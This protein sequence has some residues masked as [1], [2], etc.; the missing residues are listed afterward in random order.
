MTTAIYAGTFDP[1]TSGHLSVVRQAVKLFGHVVVLVADNPA[2]QTLFPLAER[3][4]MIRE[5]AR[6][7]PGVTVASTSGMVVEYAR[8]AGAG[9]L[10]RGIRGATDAAF[11]T[12]LAKTNKRLAPEI[13]T[14]FLPAEA[15]LAETSSSRLKELARRGED[16]SPFCTPEVARRLAGRVGPEP[17]PALR[18]VPLGIGDAFTA[19]HYSFCLA[20]ESAGSWLLVDC[21]HPIQKMIREAEARANAG[22][23]AERIDHVVLTH[24]HADHCSGLEGLA[25]F[26]HFERRQK[27]R[28]VAHPAVRERLWDGH[29]AAGM[30]R[31]LPA[32]EWRF[33]DYFEYTALDEGR[34]V[35]VGPFRI[36]CRRTVHHIPTTALRISAG[37]RTIGISAD[38]SFDE[39]LIGWLAE[40]DLVVHETNVGVHTPYERLA[41]LPEAL[42]RKM[43]L[44]H[45]PDSFDRIASAIPVLEQGKVYVV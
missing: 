16:L 43:R 45:I 28:L 15:D 20:L 6:E 14:I 27:T 26:N 39:G 19:L 32:E 8:A 35:Q 42:R 38:T 24:L 36:E 30:E 17:P 21:P 2:K 44:V 41:A 29:L 37:G 3:M 11:E 12:E 13:Q 18:L 7:L 25:Y 9:F 23:S 40:A 34:A 33:E 31:L 4:D 22:L 1:I 5:A 10:V